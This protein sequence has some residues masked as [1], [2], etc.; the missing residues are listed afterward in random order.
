MLDPEGDPKAPAGRRRFVSEEAENLQGAER[1][2]RG[3]RPPADPQAP[4]ARG[5]GEN[6]AAICPQKERSEKGVGAPGLTDGDGG[7]FRNRA[8]SGF[9]GLRETIGIGPGRTGGGRI[10]AAD[11]EKEFHSAMASG[12]AAP[13]T[14]RGGPATPEGHHQD[15]RRASDSLHAKHSMSGAT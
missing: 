2:G 4:S 14:G 11:R 12:R 7:R 8:A 13:D 5:R 1:D 6:R 3:R 9:R 15:C 10:L